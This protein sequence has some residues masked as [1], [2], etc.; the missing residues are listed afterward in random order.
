MTDIAVF[1]RKSC[2]L[3]D[4]AGLKPDQLLID[5][6]VGFG[7]SPLE[8]IQMI[9]RLDELKALGLPILLAP[10]RKR[11]ISYILGESSG[12]RLHGTSAAVAIAISRGADFIRVHDVLEMAEVVRVADALCRQPMMTGR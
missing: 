12:S 6:G 11:F 8:S 1:L 2:Q 5:P 9:A 3:A 4:R 7:V 10:S